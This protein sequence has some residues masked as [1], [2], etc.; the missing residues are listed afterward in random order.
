MFRKITSELKGIRTELG[1]LGTGLRI[2]ADAIQAG[3]EG[4]ADH[5]RLSALEGRIEAIL[6]AVDAGIVKAEALKSTARAAEDRARGHAKRAEIFAELTGA[7]E[8]GEEEDP[9]EAAGEALED[10]VAS[11]N[12]EVDEA[13]RPVSRGLGGRRA[14]LREVRRRKRAG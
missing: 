8:G 11:G 13:V 3:A 9:F 7:P 4:T 12:D 5:E 14:R 10:L 2:I 1:V 6:G